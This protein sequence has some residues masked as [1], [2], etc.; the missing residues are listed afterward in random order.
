MRA[1]RCKMDKICTA[2]SFG[3]ATGATGFAAAADGVG[4]ATD[5]RTYPN[6]VATSAGSSPENK[7]EKKLLKAAEIRLKMIPRWSG[8]K[9]FLF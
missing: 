5:A 8:E 7:M 2:P 6:E 9:F 1:S 3:P 4:F